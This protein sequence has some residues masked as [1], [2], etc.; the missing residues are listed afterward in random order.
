MVE[1][2]L[3]TRIKSTVID[4]FQSTDA[5][6]LHKYWLYEGIGRISPVVPLVHDVPNCGWRLLLKGG[7]TLFYVTDTGTLDGIEAKGYDLYM[8]ESNHTQA[9]IEARAE[10]KRE[11]GEFAYEYR[12][13]ANHLSYEQTMDW[14]YRN[15]GANSRYVLLH[16]HKEDKDA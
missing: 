6:R 3:K 10:E 11:R 14:L 9:D 7:E 1:P 15:M 2:L 5:E 13:A 16:Q 4:V 12:A 8:I